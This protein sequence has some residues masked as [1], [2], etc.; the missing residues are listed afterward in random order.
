MQYDQFVRSCASL[1]AEVA[2]VRDGAEMRAYVRDGD[3][4]ARFAASWLISD[5]VEGLP[6]YRPN[7]V[8]FSNLIH[9]WAKESCYVSFSTPT[10]YGGTV[11][12]NE[13]IYVEYDYDSNLVRD[14]LMVQVLE[15]AADSLQ[16]MAFRTTMEWCD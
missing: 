12:A 3:Y 10:S 14:A 8:V 5:A 6:S 13:V 16:I 2:F 11:A 15:V 4:P 9:E 7:E 1:R